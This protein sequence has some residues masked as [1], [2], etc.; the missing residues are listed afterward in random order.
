MFR[1]KSRPGIRAKGTTWRAMAGLANVALLAVALTVLALGCNGKP[2]ERRFRVAVDI[3]PYADLVSQVAGELAEVEVLVPPGSS[4]HTYELTPR[5]RAFLEEA[6]LVVANGLGLEPWLEELLKKGTRGRVLLVGEK[7][8]AEML[9]GVEGHAHAGEEASQVVDPHVWLDP[10]LMAL[11]AEEVA[12]AMA[13]LEPSRAEEFRRNARAFREK[14]EQLDE[15]IRKELEDI[16]RRDFVAYHSAWAYFARRYGLV[17]VGV[18][19]ERPGEEPGAR[20]LARLAE[21]MRRTG[22]TV[23]FT[24]PQLNPQAA[25][26]LARE[27]GSQVKVVELDP[28]GREDDPERSDYLSLMRYNLQRMVGA[29][30]GK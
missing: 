23:I 16:T 7:V 20:E 18:V 2:E 5:Q 8:P 30:G 12:G 21:E 9:I 24:E 25:K 11:L 22:T 3:L 4:P 27:V 1:R 29:L 13:E 19:E 14:I 17:Q 28:L 6:D 15:E 10:Q 26:V